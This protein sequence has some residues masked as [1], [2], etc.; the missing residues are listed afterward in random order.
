MTYT[1]H[2][3]IILL[4]IAGGI[5]AYKS[6]DLIRKLREQGATVRVIL[7]KGGAEFITALSVTSLSGEPVF[8]DMFSATDEQKFGH[9]NL[10]RDADLIVVA[11]A[12]ANLM[13]RMAHG[14]ADDLAST[15]L[16]ASD[17]PVMI[18]PAMNVMMWRHAATQANVATLRKRGI[19]FI[20]PA[21]GSLACGEEGDGRMADVA[22]I[23]SAIQALF[24]K[25]GP[26]SGKRALVTS[27]PTY[28]P[29][30]P[31][32]FIGNRSSGKQGHAIAAEMARQGAD[33]VLVTGPVVLPD[34][35]GVKAIHVDT[36]REMLA[37]SEAEGAFDIA[38]CAAAVGDWR[39]AEE[40]QEKM[41]KGTAKPVVHLTENPDIL[42]TL[43]KAGKKRPQL[44]IGFAAETG[45]AVLHAKAK[46]ERKGC[47]W[48]VANEV[49]NGKAFG[50]DDNEVTLL[51][52]DAKGNLTADAWPAQSKDNIARQLV[53][54][55]VKVL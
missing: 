45:D 17:K 20:G 4:I 53:G 12:T 24:A 8:T 42:A 30:D 10:S 34:P 49:G 54:E 14:L 33:V 40:A 55:I 28:E 43:S 16:L 37:A 38:V 15:V 25:L 9:I 36:A 47:D 41:K 11:P 5:A 31:V 2:K 7:T 1:L 3:R 44:V 23:L 46:F 35:V 32:R 19:D 39:P 26:L 13:A 27:G 22:E 6:L 29:L 50:K 51:R 18:A 48:I 21:K 52:H